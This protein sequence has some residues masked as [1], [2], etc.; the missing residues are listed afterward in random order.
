MEL[1]RYTGWNHFLKR[2]FDVVFSSLALVCLAPLLF[3]VAVAIWLDDGGPIMFKQKRIGLRGE[4]FT[5]HKF[6]TMVVDAESKVDRMIEDAGG[7]ALLFKVEDDPRVTR[8]GSVL[9][10]YSLDELPQFWT[11][12]RGDMSVVGPR[13]QVAREVAE[14]SSDA[15]RRLLTKPGITGLWQVSGRSDLS[16]EESI[17]L[18]LWYVENWSLTGDLAIIL[19]T[20]KVVLRRHGAY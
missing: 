11:A 12:L 3:A 13:P 14:Y 5:I 20:L 10:R 15:H 2:A 17:A 8:L 18:D 9:R 16:V 7:R 19:K 1:P 6:R 4:S